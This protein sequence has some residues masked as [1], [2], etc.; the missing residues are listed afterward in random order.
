[1][2]RKTLPAPAIRSGSASAAASARHA[3]LFG[4]AYLNVVLEDAD[5]DE[6]VA[7]LCRIARSRGGARL[8][9]KIELNASALFRTLCLRGNPEL[10][11][12][13]TLLRSL[14]MRLAVQPIQPPRKLGSGTAPLSLLPSRL[15][16]G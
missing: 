13:A 16:P 1:M 6:L 9:E 12:A 3:D 2:N 10:K 11:S 5:Q 14:G 8:V 15:K 4:I 7:A